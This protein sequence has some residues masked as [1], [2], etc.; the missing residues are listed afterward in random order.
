M[1]PRHLRHP[2]STGSL[3]FVIAVSG[4]AACRDG[5]VDPA[6][7]RRSSFTWT[8]TE[9]EY[10]LGNWDEVFG[11]DPVSAG[12]EARALAEGPRRDPACGSGLHEDGE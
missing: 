2:L 6:Q 12:A 7:L 1:K 4:T 10:G 8:Q 11:G 3:A 5:Q 9:L